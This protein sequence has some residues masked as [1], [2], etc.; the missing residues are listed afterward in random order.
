MDI[1][2][3]IYRRPTMS[4]WNKAL[5]AGLGA[6]VG[7]GVV[8]YL[9]QKDSEELQEHLDTLNEKTKEGC[10]A[11]RDWFATDSTAISENTQPEA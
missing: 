3:D 10:D 6:A 7:A 9:T 5:Y 4:I 8:Y 2:R 1:F 11:V